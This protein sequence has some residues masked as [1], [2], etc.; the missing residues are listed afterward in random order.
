MVWRQQLMTGLM[1]LLMTG[2]GQK[3]SSESLKMIK[4]TCKTSSKTFGFNFGTD[5]WPVNFLQDNTDCRID[6]INE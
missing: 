6:E 5:M 1:T 4:N 2:F 3:L